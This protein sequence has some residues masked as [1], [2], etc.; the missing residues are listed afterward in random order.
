VPAQDSTAEQELEAAMQSPEKMAEAVR[1]HKIDVAF[2]L[3]DADM[4]GRADRRKVTRA[5]VWYF[6][7]GD[8]SPAAS[9][10][11]LVAQWV[12]MGVTSM[13]KASVSV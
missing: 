9:E 11:I 13:D 7:S 6:R 5:L 2:H 10:T 8:G 1:D 4:D 3:W 12:P